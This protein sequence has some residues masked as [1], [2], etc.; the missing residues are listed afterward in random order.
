MELTEAERSEVFGIVTSVFEYTNDKRKVVLASHIIVKVFCDMIA[1]QLDRESQGLEGLPHCS[2]QILPRPRCWYF[3]WNLT[4]TDPSGRRFRV[5]G[6]LLELFA[7][8]K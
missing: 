1:T 3:K 4:L 6:G 5:G 7:S 8:Q 2:C